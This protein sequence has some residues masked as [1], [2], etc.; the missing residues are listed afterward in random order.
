MTTDIKPKRERK[1]EKKERNPCST[2][3]PKRDSCYYVMD[4]CGCVVSCCCCCGCL[5][6]TR[7]GSLERNR[8]GFIFILAL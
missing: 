8:G 4:E 5:N 3:R 6:H 7:P 2:P 1:R